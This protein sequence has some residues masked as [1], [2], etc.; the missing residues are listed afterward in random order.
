MTAR[1]GFDA[2][3]IHSR[4]K[5]EIAIV[6]MDMALPKLSGRDAFLTMKK[7]RP[8]MKTIFATGYITPEE[9]LKLIGQRAVEILEK[10]YLPEELLHEIRTALGK[11][12]KT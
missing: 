4:H 11:N 8:D 12:T 1:D 10:P 3:E 6:I 7:T 9:R 5:D 2:V